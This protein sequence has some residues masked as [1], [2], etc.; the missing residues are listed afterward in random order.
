MNM[1]VFDTRFIVFADTFCTQA[2]DGHNFVLFR[3]KDVFDAKQWHWESHLVH[4]QIKPKRITIKNHHHKQIQ[5]NVFIQ[6]SIYIPRHDNLIHVIYPH[7]CAVNAR[8]K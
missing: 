3:F 8:T 2:I 6:K 1:Q 7:H 4:Y 5:I